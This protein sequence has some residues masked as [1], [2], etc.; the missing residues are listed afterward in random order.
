MLTINRYKDIFLS[1]FYLDSSGEIRRATDGYLGRF[2]KGDLAKFFVGHEGYA[3][4][5]VPRK[6]AIVR[7][8]HL[9]LLLN[10]VGI[11]EGNQVDHIDGNR[12][13]DSIENLRVVINRVNSCNRKQRSDNTSGHTGIRWSESHKHFVIRKTVKGKRI[14]RSRKTIEDA[15][16]VLQELTDMDEDYTT[17]HG[18]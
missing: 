13:N 5:Q 17:R 6:R 15:L 8:S 9:V 11:P 12:Q 14:S 16:I 1:E 18:K 2:N 10:G 7:K 3:Y 4:I